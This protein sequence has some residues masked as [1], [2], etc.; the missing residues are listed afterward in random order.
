M[1]VPIRG[2][3]ADGH[4]YIPAVLESPAGRRLYRPRDPSG[5]EAHRPGEGIPPG[6]AAK[7]GGLVPWGQFDIPVVGITGSVGK[8]T[9]KEMVAQA[10]TA[11]FRVLK[12][13]GNQNSQIGV[14]F[15]VCGLKKEHTAAAVELGR[16]HPGGKWAA[17]P[18]WCVPPAP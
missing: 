5:G 12:T 9:A 2:E 6:G 7:S 18:L 15:T 8:T 3:R 1:F 11:K 13:A 10:L 4:A 16:E 17:S 14:P